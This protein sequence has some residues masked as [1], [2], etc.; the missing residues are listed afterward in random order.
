MC[1]EEAQ[2]T[3][4]SEIILNTHSLLII[5][6]SSFH[7]ILQGWASSAHSFSNLFNQQMF[8]ELCVYSKDGSVLQTVL[9]KRPTAPPL[10]EGRV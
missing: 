2:N 6:V 10:K 5:F 3:L 7:W 8:T 4:H 1:R 9:H